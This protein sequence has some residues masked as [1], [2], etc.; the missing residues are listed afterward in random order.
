MSYAN[1]TLYNMTDHDTDTPSAE[2][3][4]GTTSNGVPFLAIPPTGD[5]ATAPIVVLWH[6]MDPPRTEA[7]FAAALPLDGLDAWKLYLGLPGFG[8]R[9]PEGGL[10]E[11]MG[12]LATD[13]PG[14][15]PRPDP[16]AGGRRVP[17]RVRRPA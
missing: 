15:R 11:I 10:D 14:P 4:T 7:A 16:L 1:C 8:P 9:S 3:I 2:P 12:K 6:L 5:R 17:G 13:A